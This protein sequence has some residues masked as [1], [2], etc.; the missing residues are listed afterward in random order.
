MSYYKKKQEE[1]E[2]SRKFTRSFT[3]QEG[4]VSIWKYDLDKFNRGPIEVEQI[5]PKDY[6]TVSDKIKKDNKKLP[7]SQQ[8]FLNP[9][10]GRMVGY[11]RAKTLGII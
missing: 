9:D 4:V 10:N 11:Y 2:Q 5:Y 7:K 6:L 1:L 8:K 3:D